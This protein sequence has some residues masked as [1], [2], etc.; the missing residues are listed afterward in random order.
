MLVVDVYTGKKSLNQ[1][2]DAEKNCNEIPC[3]S[4][5]PLTSMG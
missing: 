3:L 1:F 2:S 4:I 5:A